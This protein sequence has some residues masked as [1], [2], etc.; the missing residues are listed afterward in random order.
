MPRTPRKAPAPVRLSPAIQ[1][2]MA[3]MCSILLFAA[4]RSSL[5]SRSTSRNWA[6]NTPRATNPATIST[7]ATQI[8]RRRSQDRRGK[9][10]GMQFDIG[11]V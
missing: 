10:E 4:G 2:T 9:L 3:P 11:R 5:A 7:A 6:H 8:V 1:A